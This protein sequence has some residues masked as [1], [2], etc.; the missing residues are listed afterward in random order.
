MSMNPGT[1]NLFFGAGFNWRHASA[2]LNLNN[3]ATGHVGIG[4]LSVTG[5]GT[6]T[7]NVQIEESAGLVPGQTARVNAEAAG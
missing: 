7:V 4:I 5:V 3:T 2:A 6:S 1:T